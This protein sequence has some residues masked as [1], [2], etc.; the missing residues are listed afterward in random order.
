M[1]AKLT[2]A[3]YPLAETR[4]DRIKG[5]RGKS[6]DDITLDSVV[7]GR[8]TMEDLRITPQ[9]LADQAEISRAAGRPTLALNFERA[10][11]L[12]GVPQDF[13]MSS[14][15]MLR[16]GRAKSRDQLLE[17][18]NTFRQVYKAERMAKF[19]E[20][21]ADTYERRGLFTYRF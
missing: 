1:T 11:E 13:I 5:K 8:V 17:V 19:I 10:A 21:A 16:P 2:V 9:A 6:L 14:Y 15:E 18:A 7:A 3:D 4:S 12:V 20:E